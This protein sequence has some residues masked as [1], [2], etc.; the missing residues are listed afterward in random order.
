MNDENGDMLMIYCSLRGD[1]RG[2]WKKKIHI[3]RR[4]QIIG[5]KKGKSEN[6]EKNQEADYGQ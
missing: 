1:G 2:G 4:L 3:L 6:C 5:H